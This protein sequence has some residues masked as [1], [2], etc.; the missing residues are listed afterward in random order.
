[1]SNKVPD[2]KHR[3]LI[4]MPV[5]YWPKLGQFAKFANVSRNAVMVMALEEFFS[6]REA[7]SKPVGVE[8]SPAVLVPAPVA[9]EPAAESTPVSVGA[10]VL[11]SLDLSQP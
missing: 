11:A 2:G 5:A 3:T 10:V 6:K 4:T 9:V 8:A 1:M 7:V